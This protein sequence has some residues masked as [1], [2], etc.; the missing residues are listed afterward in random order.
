MHLSLGRRDSFDA[1]RRP[2]PAAN[3]LGLVGSRTRRLTR[4]RAPEGPLAFGRLE[5]DL[6]LFVLPSKHSLYHVEIDR[7]VHD[8]PFMGLLKNIHGFFRNR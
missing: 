4:Q 6:D 2:W 7:C 1:L 8:L 5:P 3:G